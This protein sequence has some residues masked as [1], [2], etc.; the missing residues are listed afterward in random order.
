MDKINTLKEL[1]EGED[2]EMGS[3]FIIIEGDEEDEDY[4]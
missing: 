3:E 1:E 4:E 2:E